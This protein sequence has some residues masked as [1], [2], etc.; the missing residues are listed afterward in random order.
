VKHLIISKCLGSLFIIAGTSIATATLP[1]VDRL[2][3]TE[4][5]SIEKWKDQRILAGIS[6]LET[7]HIANL[8]RLYLIEANKAE[9]TGQEG[10][11]QIESRQGALD[12]DVTEIR[13][14]NASF[15]KGEESD[16]FKRRKKKYSCWLK[17]EN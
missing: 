17:I 11:S 5:E 6:I 12:Q 15:S 10:E 14:W 16:S 2:I 4:R 1:S 8:K 13:N 3:Q 7:S 9:Y